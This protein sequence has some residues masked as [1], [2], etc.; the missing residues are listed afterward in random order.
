[1]AGRGFT[2]AHERELERSGNWALARRSLG[3]QSFGMN[4]VELEPGAQIP[5]HDEVPH[6]QERSS[7]R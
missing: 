2:I 3:I 5:E 1:M 7:S 6:D 4:L